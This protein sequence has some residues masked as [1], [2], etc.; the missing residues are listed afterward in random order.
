MNQPLFA[1]GVLQNS[2]ELVPFF[3]M[4]SIIEG[5]KLFSCELIIISSKCNSF[6]S[7]DRLQIYHSFQYMTFTS[8]LPKSLRFIGDYHLLKDLNKI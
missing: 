5:K 1:V 3:S 4:K 7:E 2:Q 6:S 8:S